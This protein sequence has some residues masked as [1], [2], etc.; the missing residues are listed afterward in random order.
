ME[1]ENISGWANNQDKLLRLTH[2]GIQGASYGLRVRRFVPEQNDMLY[3]SWYDNEAGVFQRHY[4][5]PYAVVDMT[6]FQAEMKRY[7]SQSSFRFLVGIVG[8][9]SDPVF[10]STYGM[11]WNRLR[12]KDVVSRMKRAGTGSVLRLTLAH[13]AAPER[14]M[15]AVGHDSSVGHMPHCQSSRKRAWRRKY[16]H[17][18][19]GPLQPVL[20]HLPACSGHLRAARDDPADQDPTTLARKSAPTAG[21][22]DESPQERELADHLSHAL[23]SA[24]QLFAHLDA[25]P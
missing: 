17:G 23:H 14:K 22:A 19:A 21:R 6:E 10:L 18:G 8:P 2:R 4:I 3:E 15:P 16:H 25:R 20:R 5:E 9:L 13:V 24:P 7:V 1:P 12:D 11:L